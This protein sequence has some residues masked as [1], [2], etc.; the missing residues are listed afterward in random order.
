MSKLYKKVLRDIR[1]NKTQFINI[2][3]MV[4]LGVFVFSGIHSYMD[5][6]K[7]SA[8]NYYDENNLQNLWISGYNFTLED[9]NNVKK[10]DNVKDAE[11]VLTFRTNLENYEDVAIELN[12]IETNNISK[13]YVKDGSSFDKNKSGIWLDSYLAKNLGLNVGDN[14]TLK[15]D[16][17]K[18]EEEIVGLVNTPDHVYF[19]KDETAIFPTHKDFGFAYASINEFPYE[20]MFNQIIVDVDDENSILGV[21]SDIENNI[22]SAVAVTD[23]NSSF[24]YKAYQ[25][26]IEEG[27]TYS[28]VFTFLFLLIAILS[29]ITTM[30]RFV[31]K[32]RTQIG[33][34]KALGINR[35]KITWHYISYGFY[36]SLLASFL[37]VILGGLIIGNAFLN[38]EMSYFEVPIYHIQ[39]IPE[40]Y[41]LA[42][43]T[44]L[45]ITF[46]TYLSCRKILKEPA[47]QALRTE[48]LVIRN[49]KLNNFS[50]LKKASIST[51]WNLRDIFRNVG[52]SLMAI[53]GVC[54]CTML[55]VCAFGMLDTM[56]AY[57][58]WEFNVINNFK[59]KINLDNDLTNTEIAKIKS[60]YGNKT[61]QTLNIEF[62][63]DNNKV[64]SSI[65]VN[66]AS[67]YLNVTDH[68][69]EVFEM[70]ENGIY[71][72][73]KMASKNNLKINDS[74]TWHIIGDDKWYTSK[75]VGL[76]RDP[77][78]QTISCKKAY[79]DSLNINYKPDSLYT[80]KQIN[81]D[82]NFQGIESLE[83]GMKDMLNT[84]KAIIVL[85]VVVSA[86]LGS[87]IIYNL[88]VLSFG[89]KQYQFATLKVL[90]F[91]NKTI[92]YIYIKQNIWLSIFGIICGLPCG[93]FMID[94]IFKS[95]LNDS[96]D[97]SA[98]INIP[99]YIYAIIGSI[100]VTIVVNYIL[101]KKIKN[102][103]MVTSL[104]AN[105]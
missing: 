38:M 25:S 67:G 58:D 92:E 49:Y 3:I 11:R 61:S 86:V 9:L 68:N 16:N 17:M 6:M 93:Y 34:M 36:V 56:N 15:Y 84:V 104:K 74:V 78:S 31:R 44:V 10:L 32:E 59:Y 20:A 42:L 4:F 48:S 47:S 19:V 70:Q 81:E 73:E 23:R 65:T 18:L 51:K 62:L 33:T 7:Y 91:K 83:N 8:S 90:G 1:I 46:I 39:I 85:L 103:D 21:K 26:E 40:V 60:L 57:F 2:F 101:A 28:S 96:Y 5:G 54:G 12:F 27:T 66:D 102:I 64:D 105:E 24:S 13:M 53:V 97:F 77:Q 82:L 41:I 22:K 14:I 98:V 75:I 45:L 99:S 94:Y 35:H 72:T 29:V 63:S 52:R 79:I 37:G 87:V 80:N 88:G 69:K 89:E 100:L 50:G 95:A 30:N 71:I 55:I 76:N 43:I